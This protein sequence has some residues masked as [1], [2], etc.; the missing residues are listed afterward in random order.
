MYII[1]ICIKILFF[2]DEYKHWDIK[3]HENWWSIEAT[4]QGT[5]DLPNDLDFNGHT[6][7]FVSTYRL[8]SKMQKIT[9]KDYGLTDAIIKYL[10]PKISVSEW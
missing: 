4:P 6:S 2:I 1:Y 8:C 9:F 10:A 7:C 3:N 5:S